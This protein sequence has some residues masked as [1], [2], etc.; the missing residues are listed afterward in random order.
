MGWMLRM[1][2]EV[3]KIVSRDGVY[4]VGSQF[5]RAINPTLMSSIEYIPQALKPAIIG[6]SNDTNKSVP[7]Q[8]SI[9]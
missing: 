2:Q 1:K 3:C 8:N 6:S 4:A 7:F 5:A 9:S